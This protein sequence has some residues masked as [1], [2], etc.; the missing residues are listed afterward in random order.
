VKTVRVLISGRVQGVSYRAWT[1]KEA[2]KLGIQGW[3]RNLSDGRVEAV[4]SGDET[5][6]STMIEKCKRGPLL[7]RVD[8]IEQFPC[9]EAPTGFAAKP[10]V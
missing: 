9:D 5:A 7:A 10:T 4:F 3:V 1:C 6:V 2:T 8:G